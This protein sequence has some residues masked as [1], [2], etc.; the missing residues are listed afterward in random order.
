[1]QWQQQHLRICGSNK[2][3]PREKKRKAAHGSFYTLKGTSLQLLKS[4]LGL[5][6]VEKKGL[7]FG[8]WCWQ[9]ERWNESEFRIKSVDLV[10]E[11]VTKRLGLQW[12]QHMRFNGHFFIWESLKNR[13][14]QREA[15]FIN[16]C[17]SMWLFY[18]I[19][20][21][22]TACLCC[23]INQYTHHSWSPLHPHNG[24]RGI[25][26][27]GTVEHSIRSKVHLQGLRFCRHARTN[28]WNK[29]H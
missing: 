22:Y 6:S 3:A 28:C 17:Y 1:M 12:L 24:K 2:A 27:P 26:R 11:Q 5:S 7:G 8:L 25:P 29:H 19:L 16:R 10:W 23:K 18:F 14:F 21:H 9:R 13:L 4:N 20:Q 15:A